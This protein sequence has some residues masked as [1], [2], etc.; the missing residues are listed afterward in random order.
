MTIVQPRAAHG[1]ALLRSDVLYA[2]HGGS[3]C[4]STYLLEDR[5]IHPAVILIH[6]G[7]WSY[8]E[9]GDLASLAFAFVDHGYAA[10]TVDYRLLP[11]WT[12]PAPVEDARAAVVWIRAHA[13]DLRVDPARI[14][15]LGG[16]AGGF[17]AASL[18][19]MGSGDR[20]PDPGR[21]RRIVVG[22]DR[23]GAVIGDRGRE[24]RADDRTIPGMR[25]GRH[26]SR[27]ARQA[28]PTSFVDTGDAPLLVAHAVDEKIPVAQALSMASAYE[29]AGAPTN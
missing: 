22:A 16:S 13:N 3:T 1:S 17:I 20:P 2:V 26:L 9:R 7:R 25:A 19:T 27:L 5:E 12:Y 24:H 11:G 23:P 29:R 21:R 15:A 18:A 4:T 28:S 14:G 6:G 8:G 10:F